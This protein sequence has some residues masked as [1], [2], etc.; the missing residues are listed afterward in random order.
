VRDTGAVLRGG[1]AMSRPRTLLVVL[2]LVGGCRLVRSD[3]TSGIMPRTVAPWRVTDTL[4]L[5][6][7]ENGTARV[8]RD[9][10]FLGGFFNRETHATTQVDVLNLETGAWR[11]AADL[12]IAITH[13]NA[14]VLGDTAIWIVGGFT[15]NHPGP[16]TSESWRYRI[17]ADTWVPGP[18]L[19]ASRGGGVTLALGDTLHHMGGWLPDRNTDSPD[20]WR[21]VPGAAAWEVRAP[22][23]VPRGHLTGMVHGGML[24]AIGGNIGHDPVPVDVGL[25]HRYD[26]IE[27][28]WTEL[29]RLARPRSHTE[30]GTAW[31]RDRVMLIGGRDLTSWQWNL[32]Q[33]VSWNPTTHRTR[34]EALLPLGLLA[35][36]G[37][38]IGDTLI[39]GAGAPQIN[40]PTNRLIWRAPITGAWHRFP[41]MPQALGHVAAGVI[42]DRLFIVGD[43]DRLTQVFHLGRGEWESPARWAAR[44]VPGHHHSAEV[45]GDKLWLIGSLGWSGNRG[46]V[47]V[48][49]P[50]L[51][52]WRLGPPLP[53]PLG[54]VASAVI[55]GRIYVAG[56]IDGNRTT[57]AGWVLDPAIG[58]WEPIAPMPWPRH[59]AAAA[60]D[61]ERMFV[62]GGRG[63]DSEDGEEVANGHG[64]VQIY[65]PRTNRW[66]TSD[67]SP[68][69]PPPLP[70]HRGGMGKAIY[71]DRAFW[72]IGGETIDGPGATGS[73]TYARVD[74]FD[75]VANSWQAGP[76]LQVARQGIFPV[77]DDGR[78]LVVGGGTSSG[79]GGSGVF[80]VLR[81]R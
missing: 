53:R 19:P 12:P 16:T 9:L 14:I 43:G 46:H 27:D 78:V 65:D 35:P 1:R 26:P 7:Y 25:V 2:A 63:P 33:V 22:M 56:G 64:D 21:L 18:P 71:L 4:P 15:G 66:M 11:R 49:D 67:G 45:L 68:G 80:E 55:A 61:G 17:A 13:A 40:D 59:L 32:D 47:Q 39:V 20:H 72:V 44:P 5:T 24:Y 37:A 58:R 6:R 52:E 41:E 75:P 51:N 57:G 74:I 70:Q 23:P 36:T 28:R 50:V 54:S 62:F 38:V 3:D 79:R 31:W 81:P 10:Y 29:P 34:L 8:G 60:T 76:P 73:G 77:V 48:F 69:A 42:E 30:P